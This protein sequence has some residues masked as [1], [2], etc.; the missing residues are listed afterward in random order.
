MELQK[1]YGMKFSKVYPLLLN[2]A[3]RKGRTK[4]EVDE[5]IRWLTGYSQAQ[6]EE[7]AASCTDYGT[8]FEQAPRRGENSRL[9]TGAVCGVWVEEMKEPLLREIRC[10]DKLI[11]ELSKGRPLE[12]ILRAPSGSRPL[13]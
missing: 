13:P 12:K 4:A 9:V 8:F 1:I 10:L 6:L 7:L 3:A 5:V 2:K 11:D